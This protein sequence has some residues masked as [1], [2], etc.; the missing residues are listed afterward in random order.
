MVFDVQRPFPLRDAS[1][2]TIFCC[3][4]LEH[5][6]DP[7]TV[8]GEF[9]RVLRPGGHV[10]LSVPFLFYLHDAPRDYF[11]FT[12]YG[13]QSLAERARLDV[14]S[15]ETSGGLGHTALNAVTMVVSSA[16]WSGRFPAPVRAATRI[17]SALARTLDG[18][19]DRQ[20]LFAQSVN[21]V[22]RRAEGS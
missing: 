18:A 15:C 20:G 13:V 19:G 5:V 21:V 6:P 9:R 12:R 8:L 3:S 7:W 17:G 10:I 4:V 2:D 11:R 1:L 16:L 14:V 22:L